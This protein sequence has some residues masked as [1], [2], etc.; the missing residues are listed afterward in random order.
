MQFC[1]FI[2]TCR[3]GNRLAHS[4]AKRVVLAADTDVWLEEL[5]QD[6]VNVFQFDL[7]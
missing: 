3:G 4:L 7:S 6:L 5:P 1:N 2:H